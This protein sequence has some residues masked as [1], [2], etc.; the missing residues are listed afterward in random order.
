MTALLTPLGM[1]SGAWDLSSISISATTT[2]SL[3]SV[4]AQSSILVAGVFD[5]IPDGCCGKSV[6]TMHS[7]GPGLLAMV[8]YIAFPFRT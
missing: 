8:A 1:S 6:W 2:T 3:S 5:A 4:G 7:A